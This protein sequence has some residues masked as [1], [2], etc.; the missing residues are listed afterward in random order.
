[1]PR[2]VPHRYHNVGTTP[3]KHWLLTTPSGFEH[4]FACAEEFAQPGGPD[5]RRIV[6]IHAAYGIE[7]LE[8][9][10]A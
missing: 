4:F 2:G 3:S 7:L 10:P 9:P 8:A 6:E 1:L 5:M